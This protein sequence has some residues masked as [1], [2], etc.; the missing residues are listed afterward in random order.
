MNYQ[1][2]FDKLNEKLEQ[3]IV[4]LIKEGNKR[5][6]IADGLTRF[7][8]TNQR[9]DLLASSKER[10]LAQDKK[11][12]KRLVILE[13]F[14]YM[15]Y[16]DK[17]KGLV[18]DE[19]M[20]IEDCKYFSQTDLLNM[21]ESSFFIE[22][23]IGNYVELISTVKE[24]YRSLLFMDN[25]EENIAVIKK[26]SAPFL[27]YYAPLVTENPTEL[28][29]KAT[30]DINFQIAR[31]LFL[32][33][34]NYYEHIDKI[35]DTLNNRRFLFDDLFFSAILSVKVGDEVLTKEEIM[36]IMEKLN[37]IYQELKFT[38][39]KE[40]IAEKNSQED[41]VKYIGYYLAL[42]YQEISYIKKTNTLDF[43]EDDVLKYIEKNS[44][45]ELYNRFLYDNEFS[46][47][48]LIAAMEAIDDNNLAK[49]NLLNYDN[50]AYQKTL[51]KLYNK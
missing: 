25:K 15:Q 17:H 35:F 38:V 44:L 6:G 1:T 12:L 40:F 8:L 39:L 43:R 45:E 23:F 26:I 37:K 11:A 47:Y 10:T 21:L 19:K 28:K 18:V 36:Q 34:Y 41:I 20:L 50:S 42:A 51:K 29:L 22:T 9:D 49:I 30:L 5:D 27:L 48:A 7:L 32:D 16:L 46:N 4:T 24:E 33:D 3:V 31:N 2:Y 13:A 14:I